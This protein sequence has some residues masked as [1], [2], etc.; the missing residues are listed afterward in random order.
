[1]YDLY[2]ISKCIL[3][4]LVIFENQTILIVMRIYHRLL[5]TTPHTPKYSSNLSLSHE[6]KKKIVMQMS[7]IEDV[8][9]KVSL[10][11]ISGRLDCDIEV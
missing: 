8:Y 10:S 6:L 4:V 1:M 11:L 3:R 7:K 5:L 2:L 9:I